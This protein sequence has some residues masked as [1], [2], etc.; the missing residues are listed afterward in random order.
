M[1]ISASL[2]EEQ[3]IQQDTEVLGADTFHRQHAW[4]A[5]G[6]TT[7]RIPS[8]TAKVCRAYVFYSYRHLHQ[9]KRELPTRTHISD[10][11][12]LF[13]HSLNTEFSRHRPRASK[14]TQGK[15]LSRLTV[16]PHLR[17][18]LDVHKITRTR[19]QPTMTKTFVLVE[20]T[21]HESIWLNKFKR[22]LM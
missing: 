18:H 8:Q 9:H 2:G 6:T 16:A 10:K 20:I 19:Y 15:T 13:F 5:S 7:S 4:L 12:Y 17:V 22:Y 1:P 21:N 11:I 3:Q 14:I